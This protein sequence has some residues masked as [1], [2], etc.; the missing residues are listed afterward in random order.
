[1]GRWPRN[2]PIFVALI[3]AAASTFAPA[4]PASAAAISTT[5]TLTVGTRTDILVGETI[6][7]R[8][9]ITNANSGGGNEGLSV[10]ILMDGNP[11]HSA[12]TSWMGTVGKAA[13]FNEAGAHEFVA[14]FAGTTTYPVY[15]P[16]ESEPVTVNV[17]P[18]PT[19]DLVADPPIVAFPDQTSTTFTMT[20]SPNLGGTV[21]WDANVVNSPGVT[22]PVD[23]NGQVSWTTGRGGYYG[24]DWSHVPYGGQYYWMQWTPDG[25]VA[26]VITRSIFIDTTWPTNLSVS[27]DHNA[28]ASDLIA[29]Q[30]AVVSV[31]AAP[32]TGTDGNRTR[33]FDGV[34]IVYD[35]YNG[36]R[37]LIATM[38][39]KPTVSGGVVFAAGEHMV[40]VVYPGNG[41]YSPDTATTTFTVLPDGSVDATGIGLSRSTFYPYRDNYYDSVAIKGVRG[42]QIGVTAKV[43]NTSGKRVRTLYASTA[44]GPYSIIWNGRTSGGTQVPSGKYRVVQSLNDTAGHV[45]TVT[46]YVNVSAKR[47]YWHSK[48]LTKY[49]ASYCCAQVDGGDLSTRDS[50]FYRGLLVDGNQYTDSAIVGWAFYLEP[51]TKYGSLTF[52]VLGRSAP[53]RGTVKLFFNRYVPSDWGPITTA[54]RSYGWYSNKVS[55]AGYYSSTRRVVGQMYAQGDNLGAFDVAKVQLIY[56]YAI[57]K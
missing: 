47:L 15:A 30:V 48:T 2:A 52:K 51:A 45:M 43:Y 32:R 19:L 44:S 36:A 22:I 35:T 12:K 11:W 5:L 27:V 7:V 53:G 10:T 16:S 34:F 39:A 54:G 6:N 28:I 21:H 49:G 3:L 8:A 1:M 17:G 4:E 40:D 50:S 25:A 9:T 38:T 31:G 57:L 29:G 14:R 56:R 13:K 42:E 24:E 20:L 23:G 26:P 33:V 18:A 46:K 41:D 55:P 37:K